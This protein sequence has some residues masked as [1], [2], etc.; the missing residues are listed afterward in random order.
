[1]ST[2]AGGSPLTPP[3]S[4]LVL[5]VLAVRGAAGSGK[6]MLISALADALRGDGVRL[7]TAEAVTAHPPDRPAAD[8]PTSPPDHATVLT[9]PGGGRLT[10][11]E[12]P[13]LPQLRQIAASAEPHATLLLI[14]EP[15]GTILD[16]PSIEIGDAGA[17]PGGAER[18]VLATL[19]PAQVHA[20][21]DAVASGQPAAVLAPL[22]SRIEGEVAGND[23]ST[24]AQRLRAA[25]TSGGEHQAGGGA[26]ERARG[27]LDRGLRRLRG[28]RG[29]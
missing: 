22:L 21:F 20:A 1:M 10:L 28:G 19:T 4:P 26:G 12:A 9:L 11:N 13:P 7:V 5:G 15:P 3:P 8:P 2:S 27:L 6:S 25:A 29:A 23:P 24:V 17:A 14:E 18:A 16:A